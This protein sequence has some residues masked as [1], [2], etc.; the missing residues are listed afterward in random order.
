MDERIE[1][2]KRLV[3]IAKVLAAGK[4]WHGST[5]CDICHKPI[6]GY[7]YDAVSDSGWGAW[8]TM[9]KRCWQMEGAHLGGGQGQ[10]YVE[11]SPGKFELNRGGM[12]MGNKNLHLKPCRK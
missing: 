8:G 2:A 7:L 11:T 4:E 9:C 6:M 3:K 1:I 12:G 10:E 5:T